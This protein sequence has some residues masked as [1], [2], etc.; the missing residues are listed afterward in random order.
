MANRI[1][2]NHL[3]RSLGFGWA[4][5][6]VGFLFLGLVI[7]TNSL[8][9]SRLTHVPRPAHPRAFAEPLHEPPFLFLTFAC[10]FFA[11]AVYQP[12]TF[13]ALNAGRE[14]VKSNVRDYLL[15]ML[16]ASR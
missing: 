13:I 3:Y 1:M 9:R 2:I 4:L 14:H 5:R 8:T 12:G 6:I 15:S 10:F 11:M 16:N 7:V